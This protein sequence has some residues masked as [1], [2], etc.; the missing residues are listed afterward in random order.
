M[1][2]RIDMKRDLYIREE[3]NTSDNKTCTRGKTYTHEKSYDACRC[4]PHAKGAVYISKDVCI[5]E[6]RPTHTKRDQHK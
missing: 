5:Y 3:T 6:K 4:A 1:K 2:R